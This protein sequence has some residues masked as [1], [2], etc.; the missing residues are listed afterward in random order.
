MNIKGSP[1]KNGKFSDIASTEDSKVKIIEETKQQDY[2]CFHCRTKLFTTKNLKLH[3][4][5]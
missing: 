1:P 2:H 3:D 4:P 5:M